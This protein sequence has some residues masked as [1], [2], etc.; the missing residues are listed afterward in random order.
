MSFSGRGITGSVI[1]LC[2]VP[3]RII[4]I[5]FQAILRKACIGITCHPHGDHPV[6]LCM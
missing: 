5:E 2:D 1:K 3:Q 6:A 4:I